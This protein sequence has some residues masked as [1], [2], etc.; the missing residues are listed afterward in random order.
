MSLRIKV[1][2]PTPHPSDELTKS[3]KEAGHADTTIADRD[4]TDLEVV[5]REDE[6]RAS[7]SEKSAAEVILSMSLTLRQRG[8]GIS[9]QRSRV[10]DGGLLLWCRGVGIG[11]GNE[12]RDTSF[13]A[14]MVV[15]I[16]VVEGS[17][18]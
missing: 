6:D 8:K 13:P 17:L 18:F 7:G 5:H 10:G 15:L 2:R 11:V 14:A 16:I 12:S 4:P 3:S 9:S 1:A